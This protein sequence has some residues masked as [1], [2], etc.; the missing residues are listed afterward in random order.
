MNPVSGN[1]SVNCTAG[2]YCTEKICTYS[3]DSVGNSESVVTSNIYYIDLAGPNA[4]TGL[5]P[6]G[7]CLGAT[8]M[9][10]W[11]APSDV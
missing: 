7:A 9:L 5:S 1:V 3:T 4:P 2:T 10:S 8:P 6:S 11:A